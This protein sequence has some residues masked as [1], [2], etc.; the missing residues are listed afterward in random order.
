MVGTH[1]VQPDGKKPRIFI[2][3]LVKERKGNRIEHN[4]YV[5]P[6]TMG[7]FNHY[8]A[9]KNDI[10]KVFLSLLEVHVQSMQNCGRPFLMPDIY[11]VPEHDKSRWLKVVKK[12]NFFTGPIPKMNLAI[13]IRQRSVPSMLSA[14]SSDYIFKLNE[15]I[16]KTTS[17]ISITDVKRNPNG[18][19]GGN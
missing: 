8:E 16:L 19:E 3:D 17:G 1:A 7:V 2:R 13:N 5:I 14:L 9:I 11:C 6:S 4:T 18:K 10:E 15:D 12:I